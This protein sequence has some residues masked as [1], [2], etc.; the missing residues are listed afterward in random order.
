M[1]AGHVRRKGDQTLRKILRWSVILATMLILTVCSP[2]VRA[3]EEIKDII[4]LFSEEAVVEAG[5]RIPLTQREAPY[6]VSVLTSDEIQRYQPLSLGDLLSRVP[7]VD[8][9]RFNDSISWINIRGIL[10]SLI[11]QSRVVFLLDDVPVLVTLAGTNLSDYLPV[12][13]EDIKQIEVIRTPT[14]VSGANA[15]EGIISIKTKKPDEARGVRFRGGAGSGDTTSGFLSYSDKAGNLGYRVSVSDYRSDIWRPAVFDNP[16]LVPN[17]PDQYSRRFKVTSRVN[18]DSGKGEWD[19][20]FGRTYDIGVFDYITPV[21]VVTSL[22]HNFLA[23]TYSQTLG[24]DS[25]LKVRLSHDDLG[26]E[27][28]TGYFGVALPASFEESRNELG[29]EH[30]FPWWKSHLFSW[31]GMIYKYQTSSSKDPTPPFV[32]PDSK[33]LLGF[34]SV[35]LSK[36]GWGL[37][38]Q[39]KWSLTPEDALYMGG[40]YDADWTGGKKFAPFASFVHLVNPGRS[41]RANVNVAYRFPHSSELFANLTGVALRPASPLP[42]TFLFY[43]TTFATGQSLGP[44]KVVSYELAYGGTFSDHFKGNV[45]LY[46]REISDYIDR[47]GGQLLPPDPLAFTT[48]GIPILLDNRFPRNVPHVEIGGIEAS[49]EYLLDKIF[50]AYGTVRYQTASW[51]LQPDHAASLG[52]PVVDRLKTSPQVIATLGMKFTTEDVEGFIEGYT[53]GPRI[54]LDSDSEFHTTANT[55][56]NAGLTVPLEKELKVGLWGYNILDSREQGRWSNV[57]IGS[58]IQLSLQYGF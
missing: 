38:F 2:L 4:E 12:A 23:A 51:R 24:S 21:A 36:T 44:E 39:D 43:G 27:L 26:G 54:M 52:I 11:H 41:V 49:G 3:Q 18:Y 40:R 33:P 46:L 7:G 55:I 53:Y 15:V 20:F 56:V 22:S 14:T 16:I 30:Y 48:S 34:Q 35:D 29:I 5:A 57:L 10:D 28:R 19:L 42:L 50:T 25:R 31:G 58:R 32:I 17:P 45:E 37:Y 9:W 1:A 13:L 47:R 6:S 8:L